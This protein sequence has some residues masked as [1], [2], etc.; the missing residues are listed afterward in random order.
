M[1]VFFC[2]TTKTPLQAADATI[3]ELRARELPPLPVLPLENNPLYQNHMKRGGHMKK[4]YGEEDQEKLEFDYRLFNDYAYQNF[5]NK[6]LDNDGEFTLERQRDKTVKVNFVDDLNAKVKYNKAPP[7]K[8]KN[9]PEAL[10]EAIQGLQNGVIDEDE[11]AK[12]FEC[13]IFGK[14]VSKYE[15][16]EYKLVV[17]AKMKR[18]AN[19]DKWAKV[20]YL[21][22]TPVINAALHNIT[23]I[24]FIQIS[25]LG[26]C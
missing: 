21:K 24:L 8:K 2:A 9:L 10:Y 13:T 3:D 12:C 23:Q 7:L 4:M 16:N 19:F 6:S 1:S 22:L 5:N 11:F 25:F 20:K 17:I 18:C 15:G 26:P 14:N